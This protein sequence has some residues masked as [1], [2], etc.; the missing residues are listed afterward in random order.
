[1]SDY[2]ENVCRKL[3]L[4]VQEYGQ[5]EVDG[6]VIIGSEYDGDQISGHKYIN[7]PTIAD[8]KLGN[9]KYSVARFFEDA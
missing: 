1:M 4:T 2:I 7:F 3:R 9:V 6:A 8:V 5:K